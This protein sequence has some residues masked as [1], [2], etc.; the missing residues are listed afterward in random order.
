MSAADEWV[1]LDRYCWRRGPWRIAASK[2]NGVPVYCLTRE[3]DTFKWCGVVLH[4]ARYY[5]TP[6]AARLAAADE[7][8]GLIGEVV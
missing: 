3:G 5:E 8:E 1:R 7:D 4:R 2:T 6:E